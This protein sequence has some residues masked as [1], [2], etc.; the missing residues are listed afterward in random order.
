[1]RSRRT[2]EGCPGLLLFSTRMG[3]ENR[4]QVVHGMIDVR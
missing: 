4:K 3:Y 1:M 2:S